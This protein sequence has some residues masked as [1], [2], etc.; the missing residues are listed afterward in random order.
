MSS[1]VAATAQ[2]IHGI[3][4]G[5]GYARGDVTAH[6]LPS[7][8]IDQSVFA[9]AHEDSVQLLRELNEVSLA[10][11]RPLHEFC[12]L[13]PIELCLTVFDSGTTPASTW[14]TSK[15]SLLVASWRPCCCLPVVQ[16]VDNAGAKCAWTYQ[17]RNPERDIRMSSANLVMRFRSGTFVMMFSHCSQSNT[18]C[19]TSQQQMRA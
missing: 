18:T 17:C 6:S 7:S 2:C 8:D 5:T 10:S 19:A 9:L 3:R 11:L 12:R 13:L 1:A 14:L 4:A 15:A 16:L